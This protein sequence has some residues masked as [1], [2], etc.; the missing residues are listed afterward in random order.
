M[1][2]ITV[3]IQSP[4]NVFGLPTTTLTINRPPV[5]GDLVEAEAAEARDARQ[6]GN[7]P[8]DSGTTLHVFARCMGVPPSTL[9]DLSLSDWSALQVAFAPFVSPQTGTPSPQSS[10]STSG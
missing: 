8:T 5:L 4:I 1:F 3:E 6:R 9:R 2:P 7:E 10:S